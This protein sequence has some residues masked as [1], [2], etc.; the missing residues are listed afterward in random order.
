MTKNTQ[1]AKI[2]QLLDEPV[3]L[4]LQPT[5]YAKEDNRPINPIVGD[6]WVDENTL[7][8]K[9]W[10]GRE[11][12][13]LPEP[14]T[15]PTQFGDDNLVISE[16]PGDELTLIAGG[17]ENFKTFE[18]AATDM[19]IY[20]EGKTL[21]TINLKT[22]DVEFDE[23]YNPTE[24]AKIF[25][26]SIS[27]YRYSEQGSYDVLQELRGILGVKEN[28]SIRSVARHLVVQEHDELRV[29][30]VGNDDT[31][32]IG[33]SIKVGDHVY[34]DYMFSEDRMLSFY[35]LLKQRYD[36]ETHKK[37]CNWHTWNHYYSW[38]DSDCTCEVEMM[39]FTTPP[40]DGKGKGSRVMT[41]PGGE[42]PGRD[43]IEYFRDKLARAMELKQIP[44]IDK[45][46]KQI[47]LM[48]ESADIISKGEPWY[49]PAGLSKKLARRKKVQ[50][51]DEAL[52]VIE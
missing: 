19:C 45:T 27:N 39:D 5:Y 28:E 4:G 47:A 7:E 49:V 25:W 8:I 30:T 15:S 22:G 50:A 31:G 48:E 14:P 51:F 52:K 42:L 29:V 17:V 43:D 9:I 11:W 35:D 18:I 3:P 34:P 46:K 38:N 26:E 20:Y 1:L 24:A 36:T 23:D 32:E 10:D 16:S 33:I 41:L 37:H 12:I 21:V 13:V 44:L 6:A 40:N 2:K